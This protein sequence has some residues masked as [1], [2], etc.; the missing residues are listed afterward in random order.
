V[1][2]GLDRMQAEE[3][4]PFEEERIEREQLEIRHAKRRRMKQEMVFVREMLN[5]S[6]AQRGYYTEIDEDELAYQVAGL[7]FLLDERIALYLFKA[8]EPAGFILCIPDISELVRAVNGNLNFPNQLRL[9]LTRGR[10][11][12]EA[13]CVIQGL[14]PEEQGKGYSRLLMRELLRNLGAAGYHTMR[15]TFVEH[16]NVASS[17]YIERL[18]RPL[19]GVTFYARDV[20]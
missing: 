18:G 3:L 14:V 4:L 10:Y 15:A 16:E 7:G 2:T 20:A 6:F 5:A 13:I 19:H 11:R 9:L 1:L 17:S 8:G 12:S